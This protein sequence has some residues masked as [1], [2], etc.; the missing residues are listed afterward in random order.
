MKHSAASY[1]DFMKGK[2][3][4]E[5][6]NIFHKSTKSSLPYAAFK[7]SYAQYQPAPIKP[8][9]IKPSHRKSVSTA[10]GSS[11]REKVAKVLA[12]LTAK[13][14]AGPNNAIPKKKE[15]PHTSKGT[16][17]TMLE[18]DADS[19]TFD[20]RTRK[21]AKNYS[22]GPNSK[23]HKRTKSDY[24]FTAAKR[25]PSPAPTPTPGKFVAPKQPVIGSFKVIPNGPSLPDVNKV[26]SSEES[27]DQTGG[28]NKT[29]ITNNTNIIVIG[30]HT[31]KINTLASS[32]PELV[33]YNNARPVLRTGCKSVTKKTGGVSPEKMVPAGIRQKYFSMG[34]TPD[35]ASV[36]NKNSKSHSIITHKRSIS[37]S[38]GSS[39]RKSNVDQQYILKYG[40]R[41]ATVNGPVVWS[42][43]GG[44]IDPR[45]ISTATSV[46]G[47]NPPSVISSIVTKPP[48]MTDQHT[49]EN[50]VE[51]A[52]PLDRKHG[53]GGIL[54]TT[55]TKKTSELFH[56]PLFINSVDLLEKAD[57]SLS[58]KRII[59]TITAYIDDQSKAKMD[60]RR[61][62]EM[63]ELSEYIKKVWKET[64][65]PPQTT[66]AFYKIGKVLGKG[67]FGKVNLGI[68]K[69]S[70][71]FVAIKS[72]QK[73]VMKD[74]TSKNKVLREV[75]IWEQLSHPSIIR[76]IH[77]QQFSNR[78]YETFESEKHLLYVE[79]LCAGGDL[80]TYVRKRRRLKEVVA[81]FILKQ[82]LDG[83]YY[84]HSK[85]ILHRD[86]KLDNILLNGEGDIKV[87]LLLWKKIIDLRLWSEQSCQTRRKNN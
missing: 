83:L 7:P 62:K 4:T 46:S 38:H 87:T 52:Y 53:S 2:K 85:N 10:Q 70:G 86:I 73:Q 15:V 31:C 60:P 56:Q 67:A 23:Y 47:S 51:L 48:F 84:C 71:K 11:G 78:L 57:I 34:K 49:Q 76:Y 64:R 20:N 5:S 9:L 17:F 81:K 13:Y 14:S 6:S 74:E 37:D 16:T 24:I 82:I 55:D 42:K 43:N 29:T 36:F 39:L 28:N 54:R 72:I 18:S 40:A 1:L 26:P 12:N 44:K 22:V 66:V 63:L 68:H 75:S 19:S 61:E 30:G 25:R 21:P 27:I 35:E 79:E 8:G 69:L 45:K 80:L 77:I 32:P 58:L 59:H 33:Q 41:K 50:S 65:K 3:S